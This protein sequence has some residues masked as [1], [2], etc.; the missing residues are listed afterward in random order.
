[1]HS[2][3]HEPRDRLLDT[4]DGAILHT[5]SP[6]HRQGMLVEGQGLPTWLFRIIDNAKGGTPTIKRLH[7][8]QRIFPAHHRCLPFVK[9]C[10]NRVSFQGI[11]I[12][13][14]LDRNALHSWHLILLDEDT[15]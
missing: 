9:M 10:G 2:A 7:I 12:T 15:E 4:D 14:I 1:M 3:H 13:R 11:L 5:V 8:P 6:A